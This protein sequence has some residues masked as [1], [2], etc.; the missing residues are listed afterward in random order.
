MVEN[1]CEA[2]GRAT[3]YFQII[4][5][6]CESIDDEEATAQSLQANYEYE[7]EK[8][9]KVP[10]II[11]DLLK[12]ALVF[13]CIFLGLVVLV[14]IFGVKATTFDIITITVLGIVCLVAFFIQKYLANW[15]KKNEEAYNKKYENEIK[16]QIE[17]TQ[18]N[19]DALTKKAEQF[20]SENIHYIEFLPMQ[21][22]NLQAVTFMYL[23]V[24][25]GRADTLKEAINL[26]EEQ[27]HRWKLEEYAQEAAEAE[28]YMASALDELNTRQ[29]E[30]NAHLQAIE[31]I[32][33]LN[34]LD[35]HS[36]Q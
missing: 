8:S 19:T 32:E 10:R 25:N 4:E 27:L 3:R 29:A 9:E 17:E 11:H 6:F 28:A 36:R 2:L 23:A 5:A 30:T 13:G 1:P 21:Y 22:R 7:K 18:R 34:Y 26:Y 14:A 33:Y 24:G 12:V 15:L 20:I 16:P 31:F 35:N